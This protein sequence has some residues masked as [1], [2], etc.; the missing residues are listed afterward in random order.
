MPGVLPNTK[1]E[2]K[3]KKDN[4]FEIKDYVYFINKKKQLR[5]F[6]LFEC[7]DF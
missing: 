4:S 7:L 6:L 3:T 5:L 2:T 1:Y